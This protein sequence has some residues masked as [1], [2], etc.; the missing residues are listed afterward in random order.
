MILG[1]NDPEPFTRTGVL[2][3]KDKIREDPKSGPVPE[4]NENFKSKNLG[5]L[6]AKK[7]IFNHLTIE[8]RNL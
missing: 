1:R 2:N 7:E 5:Y 8:L 4:I 6:V 3:F